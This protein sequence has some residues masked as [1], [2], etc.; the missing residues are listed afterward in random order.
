MV[1]NTGLPNA[2]RYSL[3]FT[4]DAKGR[5][6]QKAVSLWN[7]SSY[8]LQYTRR[9]LYDG[10]N[11]VAEL[12]G[13]NNLIRSYIWGNDLSGSM[14]GAGGV[15]G[16]LVVKPA[17]ANPL[18]VAYDGNGN[19]VGLLDASTGTAVAQYAYGPFGE[20]LQMTPNMGNPCPLRFSTKYDDDE[21]DLI[22]YGYRYYN[23]GTG[24]WPSRDPLGELG[25][26]LLN[27]LAW[28][29]FLGE[30]SRNNPYAMEENNPVNFID[31]LGLQ[32]AQIG[33]AEAIASG[34]VAQIEA[35]LAGADGVLSD[36]EIAAAR[37]FLQRVAT[38]EAIY[39]AYKALNCKGCNGCADKQ[40]AL[41]NGACLTAEIAGRALYL[42]NK[43]DYCLAGSIARGSQKAEGG[44]RIELA[45]KTRAL[46]KCTAA[47][48]TLPSALPPP[49][50]AP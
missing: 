33:L 36:A 38:C 5:R 35:I 2:A 4:Y 34:N 28:L 22:Y 43:C 41:A 32:S 37:A 3:S 9:F 12:D 24:R 50:S 1:A 19:V 20:V 39:A 16:L 48:L 15:G 40:S 46:A 26:N 25:A 6:I 29:D 30:G 42:K 18:F 47:A 10:W 31:A 27:N 45:N 21:T 17:S 23:P 49:P 7:G 14:Q 8:V 44:H 13:S 11:V